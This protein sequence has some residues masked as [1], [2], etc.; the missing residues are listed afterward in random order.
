[1]F[2]RPPVLR[3]TSICRPYGAAANS[4]NRQAIKIMLLRSVFLA[5]QTSKLH[6]RAGCRRFALARP[7]S[8][9]GHAVELGRDVLSATVRRLPDP[10]GRTVCFKSIH[11]IEAAGVLSLKTQSPST[12]RWRLRVEVRHTRRSERTVGLDTPLGLMDSRRYRK[13][14]YAILLMSTR[15]GVCR[16]K[17]E[18]FASSGA[19]PYRILLSS[20]GDADT[21]GHILRI[22]VSTRE[23]T[24]I[25]N[26]ARN[27]IVP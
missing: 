9:I 24:V 13:R 15:M 17:A 12:L 3:A 14:G 5:A 23:L 19:R 10:W 25:I 7:R 20:K 4:L 16:T 22:V 8:S 6:G 1:M 27:A 21:S 11:C 26:V 2:P 18:G